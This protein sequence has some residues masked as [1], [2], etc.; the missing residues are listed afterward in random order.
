MQYNQRIILVLLLLVLSPMLVSTA[1]L[2]RSPTNTG[3]THKIMFKFI[4][5]GDS[6]ICQYTDPHFG[7]VKISVPRFMRVY[8]GERV[9]EELSYY[10]RAKQQWSQRVVL[11]LMYFAL[12]YGTDYKPDDN[13]YLEYPCLQH[14]TN[15]LNDEV[16]VCEWEGIT[17]GNI[18]P[19]V[20]DRP[21]VELKLFGK[22]EGTYDWGPEEEYRW[23]ARH[24]V[25]KIDLPELKCRGTLPE[26][27]F[28]LTELRRLNLRG[29]S[30]RGTIPATFGDL[31][32]LD[33]LDLSFNELTGVPWQLSHLFKNLEE[34]WLGNNM[35]EG[36]IHFYLTKMKK[37]HLLD[38][39]NNEISGTIPTELHHLVRMAGLFL[40]NNNI[41]GTLPTEIGVALTKLQYLFVQ[42]NSLEGPIPSEIGRLPNLN[43]LMMDQNWFNGTLPTE[44]TAIQY[45]EELCLSG[46]LLSGSLPV[47][48]DMGGEDG[49]RW[50]NL[51]QLMRFEINDNRF[52]GA[53]PPPMVVGL[54]GSL[55]SLDVGFNSFTGT[56]PP[57]LGRMK[58][59]TVFIAPFNSLTG[60]LPF[61]LGRLSGLTK[62]NLTS[63]HLVG[64]IPH[65]LCNEVSGNL[66]V[67]F[68]GCD[69][70]LCPP[71]TFHP[72]GAADNFGACRPCPESTMPDEARFRPVSKFL[73][74]TS[75][76]GAAFLV[77]DTNAD[78]IQSPREILHFLFVQNGGMFWGAKFRDW[79]DI[80]IPD[81][82]LPGI[83]CVGLDIAKI[84][85]SDAAVC[86]DNNGGEGPEEECHGI[87][88]EL[89]LLSNLEVI[90]MPRRNYFRGSIPTEIGLLSKLRYL[91]LSHCSQLQGT[92]PTEIGKLPKLKVLNLAHSR[93]SG[94]IP[95][96][97]FA[98]P[99]L[100]KLQ[101]SA[102]MLTGT[103]PEVIGNA[104]NLRELM[105]SRLLLT[106]TI[107]NT[108]GK[109]STVENVE[110]YGSNLHGTIPTEI[111][112]C[113]T[114]KRLDAFNNWL[115]GT[116]P[117]TLAQIE[118]LQIIHLKKN[119]LTGRLPDELGNLNFL[120]WIDV[121]FN[122]ISGT[123]P[124][125][126]GNVRT[127]KDLR[128]GGNRLHDPIPQSLCASIQINGGRTRS[129]GCDGILCPLG[130][131]DATGFAYDANDSCHKCPSGKTTIYLGSSECVEL[132]VE[133]LMS[134]L[135]DVMGGE[136]W[137]QSEVFRWKSEVN[138]CHW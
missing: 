120:T 108:I 90:S 101:L 83:T 102:N 79:L 107:P 135:H 132:R 1:D 11:E 136:L 64:T 68:F 17:C 47:G 63:N 62:L 46:N 99:H 71:R 4:Y 59:L 125:S 18:H 89:S 122:I 72:H 128:L 28:M 55:T 26:D 116:I 14:K 15:W 69:A 96:E 85:L 43:S 30:L 7:F 50:S 66:N 27:L 76:D 111:G 137:D 95:S 36:P 37:L 91:D 2:G 87:P 130:Y 82:E 57:E 105:L 81:C 5:E 118:S 74:Q 126:Y 80:S 32:K 106:G 9:A 24:V 129:F 31:V 20:H 94:T 134:M 117:S 60:T 56:L 29:N 40:E 35:L 110:L 21:R 103:I 114:L 10:L 78:G 88:A 13:G 70:I 58:Q 93:F 133:D 131:Y 86:S 39:S 121:S 119:Q 16:D 22:I 77:G 51:A 34:L 23:P 54:A 75:C 48:D 100:E 127:L 8:S 12:T 25:T 98:L 41:T 19:S 109:L 49:F 124:P 42:N 61:E 44:L 65:G 38:V 53:L 84:D 104:K 3:R 73:G 52:T 112:N 113:S 92:I 138:V 97:L 115:T 67:Q 6:T 45:L 123:I 33:F